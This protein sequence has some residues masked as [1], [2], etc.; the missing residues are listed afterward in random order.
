MV[1]VYPQGVIITHPMIQAKGGG[2]VRGEISGFSEASRRRLQRKLIRLDMRA[3]WDFVTL[4]YPGEFSKDATR[5]KMDLDAFHSAIRRKWGER[6]GGAFWRLEQQ[7]RG[8]PHF[9]LLVYWAGSDVSVSD[10]RRWVRETWTRIIGKPLNAEW[11]RTQVQD[12]EVQPDGGAVKLLHYL[13]KYLG[14]IDGD[15]W[16]DRSTGE[17]VNT[18]RVWGEW[19]E[20]PYVEPQAI[21]I[22]GKDWV[23]LA[24]RVRRWGRKSPYLAS[25]T[26]DRL[27]GVLYGGDSVYASLLRGIGQKSVD[28]ALDN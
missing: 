1:A 26:G 2:G 16:I 14:K 4:T 18:G 13:L 3:N 12:V 20:L 28:L 7:K 19:G 15:G 10:L 22:A 24:R 21:A 11:V 25:M 27:R 8:A 5:W 9:H 6:F 23:I 17:V